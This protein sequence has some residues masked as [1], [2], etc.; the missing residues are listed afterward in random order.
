MTG[1]MPLFAGLARPHPPLPTTLRVGTRSVCIYSQLRMVT[2]IGVLL[3]QPT[4]WTLPRYRK[5]A[6]DIPRDPC[7]MP[8]KGLML[9]GPSTLARK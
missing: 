3:V 9:L 8:R 1:Q 5:S 6:G 2:G 7:S 4:P